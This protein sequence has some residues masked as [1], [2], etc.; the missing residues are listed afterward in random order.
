MFVMLCFYWFFKEPCWGG[1]CFS[2]VTGEVSSVK[3]NKPKPSRHFLT[4]WTFTIKKWGL[5]KNQMELHYVTQQTKQWVDQCCKWCPVYSR[6]FLELPSLL[7]LNILKEN[8]I[9]HY[10]CVIQRNLSFFN[11]KTVNTKIYCLHKSQ[12]NK[13]NLF[14]KLVRFCFTTVH[15]LQFQKRPTGPKYCFLLFLHRK[16]KLFPQLRQNF[17]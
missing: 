12:K 17:F 14:T 11:W 4:G 5:T 8:L 7:Q 3:K 2:F 15:S 9:T 10:Y 13:N 1:K 16:E 6:L